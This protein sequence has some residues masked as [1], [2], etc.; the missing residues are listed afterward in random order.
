MLNPNKIKNIPESNIKSYITNIELVTL[1]SIS[2][3]NILT[4]TY[5]DTY[6]K[7]CNFII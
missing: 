7:N 6:Y 1:N 5:I 2:N 4:N 3:E